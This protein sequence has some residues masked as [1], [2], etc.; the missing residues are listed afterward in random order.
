MKTHD[1]NQL[2]LTP[3]ILLAPSSLPTAIMS[4]SAILFG[5]FELTDGASVSGTKEVGNGT[6]TTNHCVYQTWISCDTENYIDA[7][8]RLFPTD[9]MLYADH[10]IAFIYGKFYAPPNDKVLIEALR[11]VPFPG[12]PSNVTTYINFPPGSFTTIVAYGAIQGGH[13][14]IGAEHHFPMNVA[15]YVRDQMQRCQ[16]EYFFFSD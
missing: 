5:L 6:V 4:S 14:Q 12:D 8:L 13:T 2:Y 9:S 11:V 10:T 15:D 7:E 3:Q 16:I 1:D